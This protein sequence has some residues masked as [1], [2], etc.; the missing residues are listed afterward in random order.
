MA[1][2]KLTLQ[3]NKMSLYCSVYF[4][5]WKEAHAAARLTETFRNWFLFHFHFQ[6]EHCLKIGVSSPLRQRDKI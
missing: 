1:K 6:Q 4:K 3:K 5:G 2:K